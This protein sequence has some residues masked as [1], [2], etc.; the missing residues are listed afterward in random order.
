MFQLSGLFA[1]ILSRG[2]RDGPLDVQ[3][4][5]R[6]FQTPVQTPFCPF[7]LISTFFYVC[8]SAQI[9][10]LYLRLQRAE[11]LMNRNF[12]KANIE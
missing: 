1:T 3:G 8:H 7:H 12:V 9:R 6:H 10:N 2:V 5:G 11:D 4:V